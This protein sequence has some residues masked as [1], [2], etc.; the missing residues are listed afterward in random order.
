MPPPKTIAEALQ[1][2]LDR[3]Q[4]SQRAA[5]REYGFVQQSFSKWV[6][7][8]LRPGAQYRAGVAKFLRMTLTDYDALW[9][10]S[11]RPRA[12]VKTADRLSDLE[13]SVERLERLVLR[14]LDQ[15]EEGS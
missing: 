8:E 15:Q 5:C 11:R 14:L 1:A 2:E 6:N 12:G 3:R 9:R 13:E 4:M 7:G 10:A